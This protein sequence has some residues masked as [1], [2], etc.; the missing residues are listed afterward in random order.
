MSADPLAT[1]LAL[2]AAENA[3]DVDAAVALF[4]PDATVDL[5]LETRT[6]TAEIRA[7]QQELAAGHFYM[8]MLG[9]PEVAGDRVRF[10][11]RLDLDLFKQ[12][13]LGTVE[14]VSTA[15]VRDGKIIEY[16]FALTP[17]SVAR[18][19]AAAPAS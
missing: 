10:Q 11:N 5:A 3:H 7:W 1:V 9:A 14:G 4:A 15:R 17:E 12:M 13:G 18:L 8:E 19:Q 6:G 2:L 16:T